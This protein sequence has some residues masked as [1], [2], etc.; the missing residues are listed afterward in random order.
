M[1]KVV[2]KGKVFTKSFFFLFLQVNSTIINYLSVFFLRFSTMNTYKV[3]HD[4][5][6]QRN[7]EKKMVEQNNN[8]NIKNKK[9]M[10]K[11]EYGE[12]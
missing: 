11:E 4:N 5:M 1:V 9:Q 7:M 10:N 2:K 8:D 12:I 3:S 6:L